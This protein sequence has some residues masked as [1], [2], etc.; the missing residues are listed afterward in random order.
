MS[1][2][3]EPRFTRDADVCVA[4]KDDREAEELVGDLRA[5]GYRVI[6]IVEQES[7]ARIAT[8]RLVAEPGR[9]DGVVLDLLFASS[10][11]EHE[12]VEAA[13]DM[14]VFEGVTAPVASVAALI[15]LKVLARDDAD[16]PH[17]RVDLVALM[18]VASASDISGAYDLAG[19]I[20]DRGYAR[21]KVSSRQ[22][23]MPCVASSAADRPASVPWE[24][25]SGLR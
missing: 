24:P 18:R 8:V 1:V 19:L 4:A 7:T 21:G 14:E 12:V 11:V 2:R 3:T 25:T 16:R 13:D 17:D 23:S 10:G 5:T 20:G 22:S 6:A 15:A 9:D